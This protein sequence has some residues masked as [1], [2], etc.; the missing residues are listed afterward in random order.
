MKKYR[1]AYIGGTFD[2]FH[3][4]HVNLLR[5]AK[6][7]ADEVVVSLNTDEFAAR[8]KRLPVMNL[9]DRIAVVA[10]CRYVDEVVINTGGEDSKP[11]I[12]EAKP[13]VILHGDDWTGESLMKQMCLT[14]EFLAEN[15]ICMDYLPYTKG[16]STSELKTR[17]AA[18]GES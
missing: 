13:D 16:I 18:K 10:S 14:Q 12:L 7:M 8:Y 15:G 3:R 9:E 11:A 6:E 5:G 17:S 2:L 1:K 4:G